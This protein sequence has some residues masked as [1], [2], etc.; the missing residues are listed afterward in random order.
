MLKMCRG[1]G[2]QDEELGE[3]PVGTVVRAVYR[4]EA[5]DFCDESFEEVRLADIIP[6]PLRKG[7]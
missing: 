7:L 2:Q 1:R 6:C 3:L 4:E 5:G